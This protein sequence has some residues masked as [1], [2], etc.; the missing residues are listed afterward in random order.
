MDNQ[1]PL[2]DP[3]HECLVRACCS[4]SCKTLRK[5]LLRAINR[6]ALYE[7]DPVIKNFSEE[8]RALVWSTVQIIQRKLEGVEEALK[9]DRTFKDN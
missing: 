9:N 5:Y 3:C 6:L 7:D 4:K 2:I 1:P 8:Q